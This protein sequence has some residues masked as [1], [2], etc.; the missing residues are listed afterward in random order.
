[1]TNISILPDTVINQIA[2]G[3]VIENPSSCVKEII[4]NSI[5]AKA[6]NIQIE[7]KAAGLLSIKIS[8]DGIGMSRADL[9]M[10]IL[11]HA[12]SKI[13]SFEDLLNIGSLGFRGEALASIAS[14]SKMEIHSA[15]DKKGHMLLIEG[16]IITKDEISPLNRGTVIEIS[17]LFYNVPVRKNF[18]KSIAS[19]NGEI[20]KVVN[21]VALAYPDINF[22]LIIDDKKTV[23]VKKTHG[24]FKVRVE[25]RVRDI[26]GKSFLEKSFYIEKKTP[27]LE[28]YGFLG[29]FSHTKKSKLSQLLFINRRFVYSKVISEAVK[30][31]YGTRIKESEQPVF[32]LFLNMDTKKVDVNVHPQKLQVRF[33]D[34]FHVRDILDSFIKTFFTASQSTADIS[35][36]SSLNFTENNLD[37]SEDNKNLFFEKVRQEELFSYI[38]PENST[39]EK[40]VFIP[41]ETLVFN[42]FLIFADTDVEKGSILKVVNLKKAQASIFFE[43]LLASFFE[44]KEMALQLLAFPHILNIPKEDIMLLENELEFF[45]SIGI[46]IRILT[47]CSIAID[48]V[49][50]FLDKNHFIDFFEKSYRDIIE[51]KTSKITKEAFRLKLARKIC[52]IM[53]GCKRTFSKKE[54]MAILKDLLLLKAPCFDPLGEKVIYN[55]KMENF[56]KSLN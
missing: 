45:K 6:E 52:R 29:D 16:G 54:A 42:D 7:I 11:R 43:K 50:A 9:K 49:A 22:T 30:R 46:E 31:S 55:L 25:K 14:I 56:L 24:P 20:T 2:A 3:E 40:Q 23:E 38:P 12:T 36:S 32:L 33:S 44:N 37:F 4:E 53:K 1:M 17:S 26:L 41:S 27:L 21:R 5:D 35:F 10:A 19:I 39:K 48:A 8:D 13:R 47:K 34:E 51:Y 18:Q 15:K 28:F